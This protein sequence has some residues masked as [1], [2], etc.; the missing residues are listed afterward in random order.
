MTDEVTA[1]V[2]SMEN[3]VRL[4]QRNHSAKAPATVSVLNDGGNFCPRSPIPYWNPNLTISAA[5][6]ACM[7]DFIPFVHCRGV[8]GLARL[9]RK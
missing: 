7:S 9:H 5:G 4:T 2:H 6:L 1:Y 3:V 8:Y